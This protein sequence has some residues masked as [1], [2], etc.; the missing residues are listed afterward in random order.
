MFL[1]IVQDIGVFFCL[2]IAVEKRRSHKQS[3]YFR[4]KPTIVISAVLR[5]LIRTVSKRSLPL[6]EGELRFP[7]L[8]AAVRVV[9]DTHGVPHI[10]AENISDLV[11][12]QGVVHAQDRLFQMELN[13]RLAT[14]TLSELVGKD[15]LD[16]D[17]AVRIFGFHRVAAK[18][19]EL[20]SV[21]VADLIDDYLAGVNAFLASGYQKLPIEFKMLGKKPE[22]FTRNHLLAFSRMM[23]W[24]MC[25]AWQGDVTRAKLVEKLGEERAFQLDPRYPTA[26]PICLPLGNE[27]HTLNMNSAFEAINGPYLKQTGGSNAWVISGKYTDTGKPY[28][29]NDP[30]LPMLL[31]SIWYEVHLHTPDFEVA[32]VSIPCLPLVLIGHNRDIAWGITLAYTDI[33]DIFIEKFS[34][35]DTYIFGDEELKASVYDEVIHVKKGD[36]VVERVIETHHGPII[37]N[38]VNAQ[39]QHIALSS[40]CF[41]AGTLFQGWLGLNRAQGWNDFVDALRHFSSPALNIVYADT[42]GNIGY[43]VTGYVPLRARPKSMLPYQGFSAKDEW[44]GFVPFEEMPHCLNPAN[45]RIISCNHKIVTDDY[46]YFLGNGWMS[47][48]RAKRLEHL[49]SEDRQYTRD[50]LGQFQ[51]DLYCAPG[52]ELKRHFIEVVADDIW[53]KRAL[54]LYLDWDGILTADSIGGC[55]YQ[56]LR[57]QLVELLLLRPLGKELMDDLIGKPFHPLLSGITELYGH[58]TTTLFRLLHDSDSLWVKDAGGKEHLMLEA[59]MSTVRWL[60]TQFGDD[61]NNWQWGKLHRLVFEHPIGQKKPF[62]KVFNIGPIPLGGDTDTV[63]QTAF[64]REQGYGGHLVCPSYRQIIDLANL[65]CSI[66]MFAPGNSGQF[67]SKHYNDLISDWAAGRFKPMRWGEVKGQ[68]LELRP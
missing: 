56:V 14:G 15:A 61:P 47:G 46:P 28:L 62:D 33:Q 58:D 59:L 10:Y 2:L 67:G 16:T 23:S 25:F 52:I 18:D 66:N 57:T 34:S 11:F 63:Q 24:Q 1:N 55:I 53:A 7:Q 6:V 48:Y 4:R 36:A 41:Q 29:A 43:W 8:K 5:N 50:E 12:A 40:V 54:Q 68:T 45:G 9:R 35:P 60:G 26:N 64:F 13:R 37:S 17:R 65:S 42:A 49:L 31:P 3:F 30:H 22:P 39:G 20:M 27:M 19:E 51:M 38:V 32:G 21:E 44:S